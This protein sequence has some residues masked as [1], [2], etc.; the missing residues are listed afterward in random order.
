MTHRRRTFGFADGRMSGSSSGGCACVFPGVWS[1]AVCPLA[2]DRT[3]LPVSLVVTRGHKTRSGQWAIRGVPGFTSSWS[4]WSPCRT[5][6]TV[7]GSGGGGY[8]T[9][10]GP[11]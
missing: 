1:S 2:L 3:V 10:L 8:P 5:G 11:E 4:M 9:G 7:G 6:R